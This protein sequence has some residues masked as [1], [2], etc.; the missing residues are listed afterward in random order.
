[1]VNGMI[2]PIKTERLTLHSLSVPFL[3]LILGGRISEARKL[4]DYEVSNDCWLSRHRQIS[5][6]IRMIE[7]D[8]AQHAWM[9]RAVV[10]REENK[11][12]G[13]I[14]FHHKAPDPELSGYSSFAVELGYAIEPL[15]RRKGYG[16]ECVM[17]MIEWA[18]NE[19]S[20][21]D[22]I[23]TMAPSNLPSMRLAESLNFKIVGEKED[24]IDGI[25]VIMKAEIEDILK[26]G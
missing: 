8:P 21:R 4:V 18:F 11:A 15:Y 9:Y 19:Q 5:S 26:N 14:S 3:R 7:T 20:V 23:L 1:M 6:R 16:K 17:R 13:Y 24:P 10:L 12:V 25:E 2:E 22:F